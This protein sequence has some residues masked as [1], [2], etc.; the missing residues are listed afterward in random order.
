MKKFFIVGV[1]VV[2][3]NT[4]SFSQ[5]GKFQNMVGT[6][7]IISNQ[8]PGGKLEIVDSST[9]L[10]RF[11]GEEKKLLGYKIDFSKSPYWFDFSAKDSASVSNFK[12]LIEFVNDDT[13]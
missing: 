3:L 5:A 7:E 9:I 6:W 13:M 1:A 4:V 12:S 10:I 8:E 11:N 2:L